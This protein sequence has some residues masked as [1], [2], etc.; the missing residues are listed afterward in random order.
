MP[1]DIQ[2]SVELTPGDIKNTAN[3][4]K[5]EIEKIFN[6]SAGKKVSTSFMS[7]QKQMNDVYNRANSLLGKMEEIR[8]AKIADA[9]EYTAL[10]TQID[11]LEAELG[12]T[13]LAVRDLEKELRRLSEI[14]IEAPEYKRWSQV[15]TYL[16]G[17][18]DEVRQKMSNFVLDGGDVN[19]EQYQKWITYLEKYGIEIGQVEAEMR[20][21]EAENKKFISGADSERYADLAKQIESMKAPYKEQFELID[22]LIAKRDELLMSGK[23]T[24]NFEETEEYQKF[25]DNLSQFHHH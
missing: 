13:G 18:A 25:H 3:D 5:S 11:K 4:L 23:D 17:W 22:E 24:V 16:T 21:L 10:N 1:S 19:S 7:L 2:L 8:S 12:N 6:D 20:K 9:A 14:K 15:L